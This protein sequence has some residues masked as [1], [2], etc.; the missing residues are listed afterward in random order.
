MIKIVFIQGL[1]EITNNGMLNQSLIGLGLA[2]LI[3]TTQFG[4]P[5][6][7]V[8]DDSTCHLDYWLNYT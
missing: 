2:A 1:T 5:D 8:V 6:K 3:W 4:I 7:K